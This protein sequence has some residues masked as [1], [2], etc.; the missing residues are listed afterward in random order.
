MF[1]PSNLGI[2][3]ISRFKK[4]KNKINTLSVLNYFHSTKSC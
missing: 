1:I 3:N 2:F 4:L